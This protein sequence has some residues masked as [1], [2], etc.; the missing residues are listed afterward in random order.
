MDLSSMLDLIR[1]IDDLYNSEV[2][3][4]EYSVDDMERSIYV[5][6]TN[7]KEFVF[8]LD[9]PTYTDSNKRTQSS[10]LFSCLPFKK[11]LHYWTISTEMVQ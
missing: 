5:R 3:I 6:L 11:V 8:I 2:R 1:M 4:L 9:Y 7:D 10:V